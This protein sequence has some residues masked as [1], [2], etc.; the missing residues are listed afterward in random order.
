MLDVINWVKIP[1]A[2]FHSI[3]AVFLPN[4]QLVW[5]SFPLTIGTTFHARLKLLLTGKI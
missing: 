3:A 2:E 1:S 4:V 5:N